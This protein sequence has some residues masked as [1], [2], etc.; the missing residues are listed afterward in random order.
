M[1]PGIFGR[2]GARTLQAAILGRLVQQSG[3][4]PG[5]GIELG[6]VKKEEG[7]TTHWRVNEDGELEVQVTLDNGLIPVRALWAPLV[8]GANRGVWLVPAEGTEVVVA[9]PG[10]DVE[11][12]PVVVGCLGTGTAPA[13]LTASRVLIMGAE[14]FVYNGSGTPKR[15]ALEDHKH[16]VSGLSAGGDPVT[17]SMGTSDSNSSVIKV[18]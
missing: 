13:D 9:L 17:G 16:S 1:K 10:G 8:G 5:A 6:L 18:T 11:G 2:T 4:I 12:D 3:A 15:V 7:E 14:V